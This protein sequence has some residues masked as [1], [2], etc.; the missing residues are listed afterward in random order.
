MTLREFS[1]SA[2]SFLAA[3]PQ[4]AGIFL[5]VSPSAVVFSSPKISPIRFP[6]SSSSPVIPVH[7]SGGY[8]TVCQLNYL[9]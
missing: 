3:G 5:K 8:S 1:L 7:A 2:S 6:G 9:F 4:Q